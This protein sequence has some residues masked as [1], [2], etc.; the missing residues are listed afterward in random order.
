MSDWLL[1]GL[2]LGFAFAIILGG[3][4]LLRLFLN[5]IFGVKKSINFA[6]HF[7]RVL[8]RIPLAPGKSLVIVE[9]G[10]E[11]LILGISENNI[12]LLAHIKEKEE[13]TRIKAELIKKYPTQKG[14]ESPSFQFQPE[15]FRFMNISNRNYFNFLKTLQEKLKNLHF[16]K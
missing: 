14:A 1:Y 12:S 11:L 3:L 16:S 8:T 6:S 15:A 7:I 4:F 2:R 9:L 10:E 13:T 5:S